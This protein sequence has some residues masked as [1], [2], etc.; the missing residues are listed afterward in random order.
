ML[1]MVFASNLPAG[2]T[3]RAACIMLAQLLEPTASPRARCD[4]TPQLGTPPAPCS[5]S[6]RL[7]PPAAANALP[8]AWRLLTATPTYNPLGRTVTFVS[9]E[10]IIDGLEAF[11]PSEVDL[12]VAA[13]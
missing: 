12:S 8:P 5:R 10:D 13:R 9:S 11:G 7:P 4:L 1:I 6:A 3:L 2:G